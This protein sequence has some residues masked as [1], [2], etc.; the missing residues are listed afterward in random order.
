MQ[1][2]QFPDQGFE[3]RGG[4][5]PLPLALPPPEVVGALARRAEG[6]GEGAGEPVDVEEGAEEAG[7]GLE[8]LFRRRSWRSGVVSLSSSFTFFGIVEFVNG[9]GRHVFQYRVAFANVVLRG[10]GFGAV[11]VIFHLGFQLRCNLLEELVRIVGVGGN[12]LHQRGQRA[13]RR[14]VRRARHAAAQARHVRH[15]RPS[16]R[17]RRPPRQFQQGVEPVRGHE[18]RDVVL[19]VEDLLEELGDVVPVLHEVG[20]SRFV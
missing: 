6:R 12:R 1:L 8:E 20:P 19:V 7:E 13:P 18:G 4:D 3:R 17:R 9:H 16:P 10:D 11:V 5:D 14:R 15:Q 2:A